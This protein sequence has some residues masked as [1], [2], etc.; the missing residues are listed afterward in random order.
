MTDINFEISKLIDATTN[1]F[2]NTLFFKEFNTIPNRL[3]V[4]KLK[5]NFEEILIKNNY[6]KIYSK[7]F[8]HKYSED[9][10]KYYG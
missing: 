2:Q 1:S 8:N 9:Y 10:K 3:S 4:G 7:S 5:L 6:K